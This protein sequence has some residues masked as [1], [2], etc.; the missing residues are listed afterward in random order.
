MP[1]EITRDTE[2]TARVIKKMTLPDGS[3][4][5]IVNLDD[6]LNDVFDMK[7]VDHHVIKTEFLKKAE[8]QN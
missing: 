4:V 7:L 2:S 6:I 3:R 1:E 8:V 5:G